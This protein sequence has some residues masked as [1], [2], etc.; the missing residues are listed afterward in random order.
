MNKNLKAMDLNNK[1]KTPIYTQQ[2]TKRKKIRK[3]KLKNALLLV[4]KQGEKDLKKLK[5]KIII[6][7]QT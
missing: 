5:K 6:N 3:S 7:Q 2:E 1:L 4:F